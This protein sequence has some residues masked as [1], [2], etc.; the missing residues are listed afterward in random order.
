MGHLHQTKTPRD[1]NID[2]KT[3]YQMLDRYAGI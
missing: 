1:V 3:N 2:Q